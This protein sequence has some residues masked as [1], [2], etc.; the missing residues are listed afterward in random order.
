MHS[1]YKTNHGHWRPKQSAMV[2]QL[3][4]T[5]APGSF[6]DYFLAASVFEEG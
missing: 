2:R 3:P 6:Q 5:Q 4:F 1:E